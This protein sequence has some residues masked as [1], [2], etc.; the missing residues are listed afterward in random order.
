MVLHSST[1]CVGVLLS[2][3]STHA[4]RLP[5]RAESRRAVIRHCCALLTVAPTLPLLSSP[6]AADVSG[7]PLPY[8]V[9]GVTSE[10]CRG[11]FWESGKL[12]KKKDNVELPPL[13]EAEYSQLKRT[14]EDL[15]AD[16]R[17]QKDLA[18]NEA[19]SAA[20]AARVQVRQVGAQLCRALEEEGR[21]ESEERLNAL[22]AALGD[23]DKAALTQGGSKSVPA[24]FTDVGLLLDS[25]LKRFDAFLDNLPPKP[26]AFD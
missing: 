9:P 18:A 3:A 7:L 26:S 11:T 22:L 12:Y 2:L 4:L 13:D 1:R 15:R 5:A 24:G 23:A 21:Y 8:C 6:A 17:K 10:R 25:A 19:G 20:Y 14:L 16:L